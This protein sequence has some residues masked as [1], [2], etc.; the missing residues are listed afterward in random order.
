MTSTEVTQKFLLA[1][2]LALAPALPAMAQY[3]DYDNDGI[4]HYYDNCPR[5]ANPDQADSDQDGVGDACESAS[6]GFFGDPDDDGST[7]SVSETIDSDGDG[8]PDESD[9]CPNTNNPYQFD[10][11]GD[12]VGEACALVLALENDA[13]LD[14]VDDSVDNCAYPNPDQSDADGDGIGDPCEAEYWEEYGENLAK[15]WENY[16][17]EQDES[18]EANVTRDAT[19]QF[20]VVFEGE[21]GG[22][23]SVPD[24]G[25]EA[26]I[27]L[28]TP[29]NSWRAVE[30]W[31]ISADGK[32]VAFVVPYLGIADTVFVRATDGSA[33]A[34]Q[35]SDLS[36]I[37]I[38]DLQFSPDGE[39]V[40][41]R[42]DAD[43]FGVMELFVS[44]TTDGRFQSKKVS[45]PTLNDSGIHVEFE[46]GEGN[47]LYYVAVPDRASIDNG[48]Y[49]P[50]LMKANFTVVDIA[51]VPPRIDVVNDQVT[52]PWPMRQAGDHGLFFV[53]PH[54]RR[55]VLFLTNHL[56]ATKLSYCEIR[57]GAVRDPCIWLPQDMRTGG[58]VKGDFQV[59]PGD[60]IASY[61]SDQDASG[62]Y[63]LFAQLLPEA[64]AAQVHPDLVAGGRVTSHRW[65]PDGKLLVYRADADQDDQYELYVSTLGWGAEGRVNAPLV[66]G[67]DV[68]ENYIV[69]AAGDWVI[70][71][72]D[73]DV[74]GTRELF[75]SSTDL[76]VRG[77]RL[78]GN[79]VAGGNV[80]G[81]TV[82][83]S[84]DGRRVFY[85]A[86]QRIDQ[87]AELFSSTIDG[88]LN[89][90]VSGD[91]EHH[92]KITDYK[93]AGDGQI[94]VYK[95]YDGD[96][97]SLYGNTFAG[98]QPWL[99]HSNVGRF[100]YA[101]N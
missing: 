10:A 9:N 27:A 62:R 20:F 80:S 53:P 66:P 4:S 25:S 54:D 58:D 97:F 57:E 73:Q 2:A 93:L 3:L 31:T 88:K 89:R 94:V 69:S 95:V 45:G 14:G 50:R 52:Y 34:R 28:H 48:G 100:E 64:Q 24:D 1:V 42:G 26:P 22:L 43:E 65:A 84:P 19:E 5:V 77:R 41:Y 46:W 21:D 13:D 78:S 11:D 61:I 82:A 37:E 87:V 23:Y 75:A 29:G 39:W 56:G 16:A 101:G 86:D 90:R 47:M 70:Y 49:A 30:E 36:A 99:L 83:V 32:Q 72:A 76:N 79:L 40:A 17:R 60:V 98:G 68:R 96:R 91:L 92:E 71:T 38:S 74:K 7:G 51:Y 67:G 35:T 15:Q 63:E 81:A 18:S 59:R 12:G 6:G 33:G 8:V 55:K 44:S 85:L